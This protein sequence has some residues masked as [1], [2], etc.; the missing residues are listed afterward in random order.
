M[1][2]IVIRGQKFFYTENPTN[3][4][5]EI[6]VGY[7]L[8]EDTYIVKLTSTLRGKK[9]KYYKL[10]ELYTKEAEITNQ[11]RAFGFID[12]G[13]YAKIIDYIEYLRVCDEE[14]ID[15]DGKLDKYLRNEDIE[16]EA[17]RAYEVLLEY[18]KDNKQLFPTRTSNLY[19]DGESQ[20][21][22]FDDENNI[23]KYN[24]QTVFIHKRYLDGIFVNELEIIGKGR[25]KGIL[26]EWSRQGI[27]Y[28]TETGKEKRYQRK[29]LSLKDG[30]TGKARKDGY[31]IRWHNEY[32]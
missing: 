30:M 27:L 7:V 24:G 12:K 4:L 10:N 14:V 22:I 28:P 25:H 23:R 13:M 29:D 5:W 6:E 2:A 9:Y 18:V 1:Q 19:E 11:L 32:E 21:V 31:V 15:L 3:G 26:E 20:G 8:T 17:I 16:A